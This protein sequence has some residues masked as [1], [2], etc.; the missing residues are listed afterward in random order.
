MTRRAPQQP[1]GNS[2]S[3][4]GYSIRRWSQNCGNS[5]RGRR[6]LIKEVGGLKKFRDLL[7]AIAVSGVGEP[8]P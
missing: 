6:C 7:D 5:I 3:G 2:E 1:Q 4:S 8:K